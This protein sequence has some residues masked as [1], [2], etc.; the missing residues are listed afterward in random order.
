MSKPWKQSFAN[1]NY[2]MIR[3]GSKGGEKKEKNL[4]CIHSI[5]II[6]KHVDIL[7]NY[8]QLLTVQ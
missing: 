5:Y 1:A 8:R 4:I 3:N 7:H 2:S 6:Y